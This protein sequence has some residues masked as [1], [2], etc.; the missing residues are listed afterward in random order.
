MRLTILLIFLS[1]F[2]ICGCGGKDPSSASATLLDSISTALPHGDTLQAAALSEEDR[3]K[4]AEA[5]GRTAVK[6]SLSSLLKEIKKNQE[7]IHIYNFWKLDCEQCL[8][9][10][11]QLIAAQKEIG[12]DKLSLSL[13]NLDDLRTSAEVNT[14]IREN[15]FISRILQLQDL[16]AHENWPVQL[17]RSWDGTLP[18][19]LLVNNSDGTNLFYQYSFKYDELLALL[20]PL[21]L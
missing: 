21:T 12:K 3:Q 10:N 13:V 7:I 17:V 11:E 4:L 9:L 1:G 18:A 16:K 2:L 20:Q 6:V 15:G 8:T 19:T 14:Y 5:S